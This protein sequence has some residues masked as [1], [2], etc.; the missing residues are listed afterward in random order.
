VPEPTRDVY[1]VRTLD[2]DRIFDSFG[3][4]TNSYC[5]CF[6]R[7]EDLP[8][9]KL[10]ASEVV[11]MGTLGLAYPET[12]KA[13]KEAMA[14]CK[15]SD[16]IVMVDVNWRPVFWEN[17]DTAT[18]EIVPFVQQADLVKITDEEAEW[19]FG[20]P[21]AEALQHPRLVC[22]WPRLKEQHN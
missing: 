22:A 7:A 18:D 3:H 9:D 8:R 12:G 15:Q 6:I 19:A 5:D 17:P 10:K 20:I 1:V 16:T 13:M 2:G 14:I 4:D 21:R 11:V